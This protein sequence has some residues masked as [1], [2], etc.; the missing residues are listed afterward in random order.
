MAGKPNSDHT[1]GVPARHRFCVCQVCGQTDP[2]KLV[3]ALVPDS[4]AIDELDLGADGYR[5]VTVCSDDELHALIA[6]GR[7]IWV[8]EQL[9]LG[10][11]GR[12]STAPGM[13][14]ATLPTIARWAGLTHEQL[15][16]V[17]AWNA[18]RFDSTENLPGG[19]LLS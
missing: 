14:R 2:R 8:D 19:Q 4:S 12:A 10:R 7:A 13:R 1:I 9:W 11:L 18:T 6:H 15:R 16:R 17:L 5:L 3:R